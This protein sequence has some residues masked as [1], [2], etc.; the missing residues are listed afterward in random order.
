[1]KLIYRALNLELDLSK[2]KLNSIIVEDRRKFEKIIMDF[3]DGINKKSEEVE[4]YINNE[5]EKLHSHVELVVS[6]LD[7][8]FSKRE[9]HKKMLLALEREIEDSQIW[10][11]VARLYGEIIEE[12]SNIQGQSIY[13]IDFSDKLDIQKIIK[14]VEMEIEEPI[15]YFTERFLEYGKIMNNLLDKN[16]FVLANCKAYLQEKDY[17]YIEKWAKYQDICIVLLS[18]EQKKLN[19]DVNEYIIDVDLCEIH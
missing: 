5:K 8:T 2:E 15:G 1:M 10:D 3:Y 11:N 18:N 19:I 7:I 14:F 16:V 4:Y 12:I 9:I 13:N 6:P 17:E